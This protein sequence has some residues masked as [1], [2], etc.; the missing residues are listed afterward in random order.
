[1]SQYAILFFAEC[2]SFENYLHKWVALQ[3]VAT[4]RQDVLKACLM[5]TWGEESGAL[6]MSGY[7]G[8]IT[9]TD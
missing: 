3:T 2:R 8:Q 6:I 7:V 1:M 9:N 5:Q 4:K